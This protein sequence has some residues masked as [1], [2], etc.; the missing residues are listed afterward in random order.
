[1]YML[2]NILLSAALAQ[3]GAASW[4]KLFQD[5]SESTYVNVAAGSR[6]K[7]ERI[8]WLRHVFPKARAKIVKYS[9]DQWQ[10]SCTSGTYMMLAVVQYDA[11]GQLVS[12]QAVPLSARIPA[13]VEAGSRMEKVFRAVCA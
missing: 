8:F 13:R 10:V 3:T 12:A 2:I 7:P 5:A 9:E 6:G 11:K 1:M 4:T